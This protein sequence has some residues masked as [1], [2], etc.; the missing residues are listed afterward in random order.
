[1]PAWCRRLPI[2]TALSSA[3]IKKEKS[4][5]ERVRR[6]LEYDK[7]TRQIASHAV[8]PLGAQRCAALAPVSDLYG[9]QSALLITQDADEAWTRTGGNPMQPYADCRD[10]LQRCAVGGIPVAFGIAR[11]GRIR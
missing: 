11:S 10:L 8:S 2:N 1:M 6:I 4:L 3:E 5:D 9:V 7:I